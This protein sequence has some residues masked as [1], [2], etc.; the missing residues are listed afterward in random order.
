MTKSK[1]GLDF[2]GSKR[3]D[4]LNCRIFT[5][6]TKTTAQI[7]APSFRMFEEVKASVRNPL[8]SALQRANACRVVLGPGRDTSRQ[9]KGVCVTFTSETVSTSGFPIP[10]S[11]FSYLSGK[12][13]FLVG[14]FYTGVYITPVSFRFWDGSS[15][16][17]SL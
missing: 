8:R 16:T 5:R 11:F 9:E 17:M 10:F 12:E 14:H 2:E 4:K 13:S 6:V 15:M 3:S 7:F 1:R